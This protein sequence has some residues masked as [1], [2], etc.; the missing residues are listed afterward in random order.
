MVPMLSAPTPDQLRA[1]DVFVK[2]DNPFQRTVRLRQALWREKQGYPIG[3]NDGHPLGTRLRMPDAERCLWNYLTE[4]IREV[5]RAEVIDGPPIKGRLFGQPRIFDDLLSSQPLCFNLFGEMKRALP[6]ATRV[7]QRLLPGK[8]AS[9]RRIEIEHSPG[10]GNPRYT[11]DNSAFDVY[12]EYESPLEHT[13]FLG[14]EVKY[15][16]NLRDQLADHRPRYDEIARDMGCFHTG[17]LV[18]VRGKPINQL[19]RDH[20]LAGSMLLADGWKH[21]Q[22]V[23]LY[24]ADNVHAAAA[25]EKYRACLAD[26]STFDAWTLER[27]V[28]ALEAEAPGGWT[29]QLRDRYLG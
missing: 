7:L 8:I 17:G 2:R 24:P 3:L 20:M 15:H 21:G 10:R 26:S 28:A 1:H 14:I 9:V 11:A 29:A 4:G 13:G 25:V 19:W 22:F 27:F 12:V 16:E 5:V 6:L 23:V 18:A